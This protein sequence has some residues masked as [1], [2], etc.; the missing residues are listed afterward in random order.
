EREETHWASGQPTSSTRS[1]E[2]AS[3]CPWVRSCIHPITLRRE[4]PGTRC[5][6][7]RSRRGQAR[8]VHSCNYP[9]PR[10]EEVALAILASAVGF[11]DRV[12]GRTPERDRAPELDQ[13]RTFTL[14]A[15]VVHAGACSASSA[16]PTAK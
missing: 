3:F 16:S 4:V 12:L 8:G 13:A 1:E 7:D 14:D 11:L 2:P 6:P 9:W 10:H 15:C 5:P